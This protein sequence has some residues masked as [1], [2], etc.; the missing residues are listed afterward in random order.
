MDIKAIIR[1]EVLEGLRNYRFLI[2]FTGVLFFA[3][4][5][6]LMNKLVLPELLKSQ[7]PNMPAEVMQE[8][9]ITTQ[10]ATIRG[11]MGNVY[12][13]STLIITFTLSGIIAQEISGKTL[14]IPVCTG[15]RYDEM[16]LAKITVYGG[17]L[18]LATT[19]S[20]LIN[21]GY[22]G[23]LFDFELPVLPALRAG[24]LQGFYMVYVVA[25]LIFTGSLVR[26]PITAGMLTLLAAYGT[27]ILGSI[28]NLNRYLPS[29]LLVE[30][31][32]LAA[33]PSPFL[34]GSLASTLALVIVLLGF[35]IIRLTNI[36]LTRG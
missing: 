8:M 9:L 26:K 2:L 13:I 12:Q 33:A 21:Y 18:I 10:V 4:F 29:G 28:F 11:Y 7:F 23:A 1:K 3:I 35:T 6:P 15:K 14:I 27:R 30:A 17:F 25:L 36:E 5:D 19:L 34:W 31:E 32:M 24:I 16:L 20:A 22:A